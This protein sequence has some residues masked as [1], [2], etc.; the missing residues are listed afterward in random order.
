MNTKREFFAENKINPSRAKKIMSKH[1]K[2]KNGNIIIKNGTFIISKSSVTN[3]S[4]SDS[5]VLISQPGVFNRQDVQGRMALIK[6]YIP[7]KYP[8][9][10]SGSDEEIARANNF[11]LPEIAKQFQLE[12]AEYYNVVFEDCGELKSE[13]NFR[14]LGREKRQKIIP[15]HRYLLTPSF[16]K[17]N[18]ELIHLA[19]IVGPYELKASKMIKGI[20]E[21]LQ[22]R[23]FPETDISQIKDNFI[24][25][26]IFN[27]YIDFSD[28]H[29]FNS[30]IIV[31]QGVEGKRARLAPCYD[32]DFSAG[33]YNIVNGGYFP[34]YFFRKSDDNKDDLISML[35]QFKGE[36]EKKYLQEI[37]QKIN[38]DEAIN[39]GEQYGNF[40]L[41]ERA[42]TKYNKF[43]KKQQDELES[44]YEKNYGEIE[45]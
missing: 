22:L 4:F 36:S 44:F 18:E 11:V 39:L 9:Y 6:S 41:S 1:K 20:E 34:T 31:S 43:F 2:D 15:N 24:K 10:Y 16:K 26:C 3:Y 45:R 33:I 30:A 32:L 23:H 5:W 38:V 12:A 19:D 8:N 40:K 17:N 35:A 42:R 13:E 29:N 14:T 21:Y 27:K 7:D 28:E 37:L 25:Q